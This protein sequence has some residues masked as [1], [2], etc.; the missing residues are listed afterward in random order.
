MHETTTKSMNKI[1]LP[2]FI[3][4]I[5][6][7]DERSWFW[8]KIEL[9]TTIVNL[10][11]ILS[12]QALLGEVSRRG[13]HDYLGFDGHIIL[14]GIMPDELL[15]KFD[16]GDY[17]RVVRELRP[18]AAT[19]PDNYTYDDDPLY[20][21]WSQT[22]RLVNNANA[23][24]GL[25][26]PVLGLCKGVFWNQAYWTIQKQIEM[27]YSSFV[28]LARELSR[29]RD[30][31]LR[32]MLAATVQ[33]LEETKSDAE[34]VIHGRSY[35]CRS[36]KELTYAS[37]SWFLE[38]KQGG[39]YKDGSPHD[40]VDPSIRFESCDC[41]PCNG[42]RPDDLIDTENRVEILALHN[43]LEMQRELGPW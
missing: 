17:L 42:M 18:D 38:A 25:D 3:P 37:L 31:S 32:V 7:A 13:L 34:L 24:L 33:A 8:K 19:V 43:L 30:D 40:L 29:E 21:S 12:K 15:D 9:R 27:G 26:I 2:G 22:I 4:I 23:F 36:R 39:Y 14:S 11:Q 10:G 6:I 41:G 28:L 5:E 35:R 16:S 20:L 1:G